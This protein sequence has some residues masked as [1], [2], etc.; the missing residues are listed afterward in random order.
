MSP[1]AVYGNFAQPPFPDIEERVPHA[2]LHGSVRRSDIKGGELD[3]TLIDD[4][5][6]RFWTPAGLSVPTR[7][8]GR[9]PMFDPSRSTLLVCCISGKTSFEYPVC[10]HADPWEEPQPPR[11]QPIAILDFSSDTIDVN[12]LWVT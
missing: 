1:K 10:K 12:S 2:A 7:K 5:G 6:A 3:K 4:I 8:T 11:P 9:G